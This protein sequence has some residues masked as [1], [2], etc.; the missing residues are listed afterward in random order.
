MGILKP[1]LSFSI[2]FL[3]FQTIV[4][5]LSIIAFASGRG[6]VSLPFLLRDAH[7]SV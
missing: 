5:P 2:G 7:K 4:L 6:G 3:L 1:I